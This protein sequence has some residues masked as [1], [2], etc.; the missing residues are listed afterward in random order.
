MKGARPPW[1]GLA[2]AG[3]GPL[4][5]IYEIGALCAL[6]E[7]LEEALDGAD[8]TRL[9]HYV[10]V[11]AGAFIASGL[12]NGWRPRELCAGFIENSGSAEIC[13]PAW[14]TVPAYGEYLRRAARMPGLA[15]AAAWRATCGRKSLLEVLEGFAPAIPTGL[16]SNEEVHRRLQKLLTQPGRSNDFHA[17][18]SRLHW[19]RRRW[20]RWNRWPSARPA[21][22]TCPS[23]APGRPPAPCPA[24]S[25]RWRSRAAC[26][27]MAH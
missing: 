21:G 18:R 25:R 10:G 13:D 11:S 26:S 19:W 7:A 23:R 14:L 12:A 5:A 17:L 27:S 16:F 2:L 3:G 20:T 15:L 4:G 9:D 6:E 1:V 22:T 8:F 24:C